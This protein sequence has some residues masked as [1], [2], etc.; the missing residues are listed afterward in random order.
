MAGI[1][2]TDLQLHIVGVCVWQIWSAFETLVAIEKDIK[3]SFSSRFL[4]KE[5]LKKE[6]SNNKHA[7]VANSLI[8]FSKH[9]T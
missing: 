4:M 6:I 5:K 3:S 7:K 9:T 2:C 8:L 1:K